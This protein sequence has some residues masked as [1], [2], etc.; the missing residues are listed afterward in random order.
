[1][2][3]IINIAL[4]KL[5]VWEGNVRKTQDRAGIEELAASIKAHGLQQNLV[6]KKTGK[7]F[8]VIAGGRRLRALQLLAKAGD[9]PDSH[10]VM[11]RVASDEDATEIGLAEN[12]MRADMHPADQFAAFRKLADGGAS[13]ADIA[14]RFGKTEAHVMRILRMARVSPKV[15]KHYRAGKL[16]LDAV[17]A[18]SVCDDHK[19]QEQVLAGIAPWHDAADIRAALT[20]NEVAATDKRVKFVTLAAYT[21]AGGTV[22]RDLFTEG[23]EGVFI[24]DVAVLDAL[25]VE[26]LERVAKAIRKEGWKWVQPVVDFGYEERTAYAALRPERRE[27]TEKEQ[28]KVCRLNVKFDDVYAQWEAA[29]EANDPN[30]RPRWLEE[31]LV[32]LEMQLEAINDRKQVWTPE[33]RAIAGA[34]IHLD[35]DGTVAIERGLVLPEDKPKAQPK[36]Q[37]ADAAVKPTLPASIVEHLTECRS[38]AL[39]ACLMTAPD[40]ALAA[41]VA[42]LASRIFD[43]YASTGL[44][45]VAAVPFTPRNESEAQRRLAEAQAAWQERLANV[46]RLLPWCLEQDRGTLLDL[47]AVC[48]ATALDAVW[49]RGQTAQAHHLVEADCLANALNLDMSAWFTPTAENYFGR[50]SRQQILDAL[51][52]ARGGQPPA[53]AWLKL[54]KTE[55]A[56]L[57]EREVGGTGWL[58]ELLRRR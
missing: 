49:T 16:G 18:F 28:Q 51:T 14:A 35:H 2:T 12:I 46:D 37:P 48:A 3:D 50:V 39:S 20:E 27:L 22:R 56:S 17:M 43:G 26:R 53:P 13:A 19:R 23:D 9:I 47:L 30:I 45:G 24:E 55:L 58:P 6:V 5:A 52:E 33:Q 38:T 1:M 42:A 4:N 34:V 57:A 32:D 15:L 25:V 8:A 21:K 31:E 11:C 29:N 41:T 44:L 40:Q 10:P 54:K 36:D 7:T